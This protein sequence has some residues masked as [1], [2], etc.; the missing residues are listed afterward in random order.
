M[1]SRNIRQML[2]L[3]G[4]VAV[5]TGGSRG[6]GLQIAESLG[7]LGAEIAITARKKGEL[8][9]AI[10]HLE[11]RGVKASAWVSDLG[12]KDQIEPLVG[13]LLERYGKVDILVNNAGTSWGAPAETHPVDAWE[14]VMALN[15]T[16]MFML[17]QQI[18]LRSMIPQGWGRII[19]NASIAGLIAPD[20][21][22][23]RAVA[24][25]TSKAGVIGL[26]RSLAAEWGRHGITVNAICPGFFPSRM[27]G[28]VLDD[29][30]TRLVL[31]GT[32]TGRLGN[33]ED[34]KG[35][36]ALMASDAGSHIN[37]QALAIDGGA[38]VI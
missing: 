34:L 25:N 28:G 24:Y 11:R 6:L 27:T 38:T 5:V 8:D 16:A 33:D 10:T 3:G 17:S 29:P 22:I 19:N 26:T 37:G 1:A 31:E 7:E 18:G 2:E 35:I 13:G 30:T 15:L 14:K 20:P 23:M 21:R 9:E 12:K 36:V 32:P 4:R